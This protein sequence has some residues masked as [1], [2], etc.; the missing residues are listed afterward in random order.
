MSN[1]RVLVVIP[2]GNGMPVDRHTAVDPNEAREI[3]YHGSQD[4]NSWFAGA[5]IIREPKD[6][7][8]YGYKECPVNG[9]IRD[10]DAIHLSQ[11]RYQEYLN[12]QNNVDNLSD[13]TEGSL[14]AELEAMKSQLAALTAEAAKSD[15]QKQSEQHIQD[16]ARSQDEALV[17]KE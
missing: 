8:R 10:D 12:S 1:K 7:P 2:S 3:V 14:I 9:V 4:K 11:A 16:R 13:E 5:R 17:K 6:Y 15:D